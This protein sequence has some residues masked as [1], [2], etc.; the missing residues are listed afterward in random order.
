MGVGVECLAR[1]RHFDHGEQLDCPLLGLGRADSVVLPQGLH[2]LKPDRVHR[3]ERGH[4]L[5]E[6]HR[7]LL[8]THL[9]H[10]AVPHPAKLNAVQCDASADPAVHR[11]QV[12]HRHRAGALA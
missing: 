2:N 10:R 4:R 9:A 5:L 1:I 11:Q 7:D 6:D 12:K 8:A 3:V